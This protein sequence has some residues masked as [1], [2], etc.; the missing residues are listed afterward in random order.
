MKKLNLINDIRSI[1]KDFG[2][3]GI[4]EILA[5]CS[6][7]IDSKGNLT[8]LIEHFNLNSVDVEVYGQFDFSVDNY[9][10]PY[11]ELS[12]KVLKEIRDLAIEF[13]ELKD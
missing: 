1:I 10:L 5:E 12:L 9:S 4:G 3:F 6:P 13:K 2:D 11:E 7:S 8:H